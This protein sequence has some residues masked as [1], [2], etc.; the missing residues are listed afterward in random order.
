MAQLLP[1]VV[2]RLLDS[3]ANPISGGTATF[4][5]SGT[6]TLTPIYSSSAL[7]TALPNPISTNSGGLFINGSNA[8]T[9]IYLSPAISYRAVFKDAVGN[10]VRDIDPVVSAVGISYDTVAEL[11]ASTVPAQG[12]GVIWKAGGFTYVEAASGATDQHLTTAGGVKL[13]VLPD[14]ANVFALEA[15]GVTTASSSAAVATAIE[16]ALGALSTGQSL[17]QIGSLYTTDAVSVTMTVSRVNVRLNLKFSKSAAGVDVVAIVA[18]TYS[19]LDISI[20]CDGGDC[21]GLKLE[22]CTGSFVPKSVLIQDIAAETVLGVGLFLRNSDA[23]DILCTVKDITGDGAY[24]VRGVMVS[25]TTISRNTSLIAATVENITI[26]AGAS[27]DAD[28]LYAENSV[29]GH[30]GGLRVIGGSYTNCQKSPIKVSSARPVIR[31]NSGVNSLAV[32]M[33][34]FIRSYN[35]EAGFIEGN[36]FEK[37]GAYGVSLPLDIGDPAG[38]TLPLRVSIGPNVLLS[39]TVLNSSRG[40]ALHGKLLNVSISNVDIVGVSNYLQHDGSTSNTG[41]NFEMR[42]GRY[43]NLSYGSSNNNIVLLG[44]YSKALIDGFVCVNAVASKYFVDN[45]QMSASILEVVNVRQEYSFGGF[46]SSN[47]PLTYIDQ[48]WGTSNSVR[49]EGGF[50]IMLRTAAPSGGAHIVGDRWQQLTPSAG[51]SVGGSC[52][53]A[54]TPGTFKDA[55]TFAP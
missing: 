16:T 21:F 39:A 23:M 5:L 25:D 15:F 13:Y 11:L 48:T 26:T 7:V 54:G 49:Y 43:D 10:V 29:S 55:G 35:Q 24:A 33:Y 1:D 17:V 44:D 22:N 2:F 31:D 41:Q 36:R 9:A 3:S 27:D 46:S 30:W 51:G 50:K 12:E 8:V 53:T 20:D 32:D 19:V 14:S 37:T 45:P 47:R 4:Y 28:G 38:G 34:A 52:T 18:A 6:S 40:I 42:G